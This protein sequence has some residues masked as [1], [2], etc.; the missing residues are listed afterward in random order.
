MSTFVSVM[1]ADLPAP[2]VHTVKDVHAE[3]FINAYADFLSKSGKVST[4]ANVD[5]IKTGTHRELEPLNAD[6]YFVRMAAVAR[7]V[8][9]RPRI[10]AGALARWFG[11]AKNCGAAPQK[12]QKAARGL[13]RHILI[14]LEK[15]GIVETVLLQNENGQ[16]VSAGR[17]ITSAGLREMDRVARSLAAEE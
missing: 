10:G 8:Y 13:L 17:A 2:A 16:K 3:T 7:K 4:P 1:A 12:F 5:L 9:L 11:G 6:W 15:N 14:Q